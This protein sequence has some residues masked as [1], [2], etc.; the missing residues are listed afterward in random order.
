M[1]CPRQLFA[2][3]FDLHGGGREIMRSSWLQLAG[4]AFDFVLVA[5]VLA[6]VV[7]LV[8][9][10]PLPAILRPIQHHRWWFLLTLLVALAVRGFGRFR[11]AEIR[12]ADP[13]DAW[14]HLR[15][16]LCDRVHEWVDEVLVRS[17][18]LL[19]QPLDVALAERRNAVALTAGPN[20]P[21]S[22]RQLGVNAHALDA[23]DHAH[24]RLLILGEPGTGKTTL[25][26][27]IA[28]GLLS[29][30]ATDPQAPV[31]VIFH[32]SS[33][34]DDVTS[35][36]AWLVSEL[37][38]RYGLRKRAARSFVEFGR[39]I[40]LL[41][42][43]DELAESRR[44]G[45]VAALNVYRQLAELLPFV[46]SCRT[47]E[48]DVLPERL[49]LDTAVEV[50][51][52]TTGDIERWMLTLGQDGSQLRGLLADDSEL[53]ELASTPLMLS[54]LV[55]VA[56]S[57]IRR[58]VTRAVTVETRRTMLFD[59][60]VRQVLT[61][62][63]RIRAAASPQ[64]SSEETRF[65]L[66][67]VA[68]ALRIRELTVF[69]P[70]WI[71]ADWLPKRW[72]T[73]FLIQGVR[74]VPALIL[75]IFASIPA[76]SG[77]P[78]LYAIILG[79]E[80]ALILA[81]MTLA[82]GSQEQIHLIR[83]TRPSWSWPGGWRSYIYCAGLCAVEAWLLV[84]VRRSFAL[85]LT[86]LDG[87][88]LAVAGL[89]IVPITFVLSALGGERRAAPTDRAESAQSVFVGIVCATGLAALYALVWLGLA[90][91][92][93][94]M[95][96]LWH[97]PSTD[98]GV[99]TALHQIPGEVLIAIGV[100]SPF[101]IWNVIIRHLVRYRLLR[102]MLVR[103]GLLPRRLDELL[104]HARTRLLLYRIGDGYLFTHRMLFDH[105][106]NEDREVHGPVSSLT[107]TE[108]IRLG[109]W[110]V[111]AGLGLFTISTATDHMWRSQWPIVVIIPILL[112]TPRLPV[113]H[114]LTIN[115]ALPAH[116]WTVPA[117]TKQP[118]EHRPYVADA[119]ERAAQMALDET[120]LGR[121]LSLENSRLIE[122]LA[123]LA[124]L[125]HPKTSSNEM[126]RVI[127]CSVAFGAYLAREDSR[128]ATI[129][130]LTRTL[131]LR[132]GTS[133]QAEHASLAIYAAYVAYRMACVSPLSRRRFLH[134]IAR[135]L[136]AEQTP[137]TADVSE[138]RPAGTH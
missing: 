99:E 100:I 68:A 20:Y 67:R 85:G 108:N 69:Y 55:K 62:M 41:D 113:N 126:N 132:Q 22:G 21:I 10:P 71:Q 104:E 138:S 128:P 36:E 13:P 31:P 87:Y 48:Y 50:Q 38:R 106:A 3:L 119:A 18:D 2:M 17:L 4:R 37:E 64:F 61:E 34:N 135:Q 134:R 15:P 39:I 96:Y 103:Q 60:Y 86:S 102:L 28:D 123:A 95:V 19:P 51:E 120:A 35:F 129:P 84:F 115:I 75:G 93:Y 54:V 98:P 53:R 7:N 43:L 16:F 59:E 118:S 117:L 45:C 33:W 57:E 136:L 92:L 30:A 11:G 72:Q 91:M 65:W 122:A 6:F 23:Y 70:G 8:S 9:T 105:L 25:L 130:K 40:P 88:V 14:A 101:I 78:A 49:R 56:A 1:R 89:I 90:G 42:G 24:G 121:R 46:V 44:A 124:V 97:A 81:G 94:T 131:L 5:V 66:A 29:R 73:W 125:R 79:I 76:W 80:V 63:P 112:I 26:L 58:P 116:G 47:A 82:Y 137:P 109:T 83:I 114:W 133:A 77:S 110:V 12:S 127:A 107:R 27:R 32:A 111:L 52:L 74:I